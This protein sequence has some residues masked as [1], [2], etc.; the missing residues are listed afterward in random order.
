MENLE[1]K[2]CGRAKNVTAKLYQL[3]KGN[4]FQVWP[5]ESREME[6]QKIK[7]QKRKRT[8]DNQRDKYKN[9]RNRIQL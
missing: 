7:K 1:P 3:I 4:V 6:V 8:D 2:H 5:E 9:T